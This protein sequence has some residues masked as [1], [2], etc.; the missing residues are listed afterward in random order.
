MRRETRVLLLALVAAGAAAMAG[1]EPMPVDEAFAQL[2]AFDYGK[3]TK[4]LRALERLVGKKVIQL[5]W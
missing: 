1:E 5:S 2:K 4:A 3:D